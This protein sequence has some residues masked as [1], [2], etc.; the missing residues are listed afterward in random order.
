[1]FA[2][3]VDT[4][5]RRRPAAHITAVEGHT[6]RIP[7]DVGFQPEFCLSAIAGHAGPPAAG[8]RCETDVVATD[9]YFAGENVRVT[10]T[11]DPAQVAEA[12]ESANGFPFR[13]TGH[14]DGEVYV[15]PTTVAFWNA[16]GTSPEP[17]PPP[18]P[19]QAKADREQVTNIWGQPIRRKPRR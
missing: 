11:E 6:T 9:I 1:M 14:G 7:S 15:N 4:E 19:P 2:Y 18:E 17:E 3:G 16:S 12:F 13:L 10:V 8:A 5:R